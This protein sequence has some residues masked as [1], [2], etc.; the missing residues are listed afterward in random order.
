M[1][2]FVEKITVEVDLS[3]EKTTAKGDI[4]VLPFPFSDLST[5][6]KRPALIIAT[7]EGD[8]LIVVQITGQVKK[9]SYVI[10]LEDLDIAGGKLYGVSY[11]RPNK[12]FTA[13][14]SIIHYKVGTLNSLKMNKV[15]ERIIRIIKNN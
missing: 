6:K 7:L 8:D 1:E 3:E 11:I 10:E 5:T 12:I 4:V 2:E 14:K 13:D 15:E 9:D